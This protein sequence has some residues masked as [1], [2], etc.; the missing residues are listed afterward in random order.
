MARPSIEPYALELA[1]SKVKIWKVSGKNEMWHSWRT[2]LR[3]VLE[4][5]LSLQQSRS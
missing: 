1:R 4:P 2:L 3:V 5:E